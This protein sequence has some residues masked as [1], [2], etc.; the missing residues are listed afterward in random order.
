VDPRNSL[1]VSGSGNA[2]N[3]PFVIAIKVAGIKV[4]PSFI[5]ACILV[6]AWSAGRSYCW[7]SSRIVIAITTDRQLPQ[8]FGVVTARGVPYVAFI[9]VWLFGLLA[10]LSKL[11]SI[12]END[13]KLMQDGKGLGKGSVS[14]AFSWLQNLGTVVGLITWATLCFVYIRFYA[15][16]KAQGVDRDTLPL[17]SPCQPYTAWVGFVGATVL[18]F[19]CGFP[20]FLNENWDTQ[21]FVASDVG[22]SIFDRLAII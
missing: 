19:V 9:T 8:Q 11:D 6:S 3:S 10:Y 16:M 17:K 2:N 14:Q 21:I 22:I 5:N 1:L 7:V 18:T 4:L 12:C 13:L 15:A 20:V